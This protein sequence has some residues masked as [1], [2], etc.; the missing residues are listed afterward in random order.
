MKRTLVVALCLMSLARWRRPPPR[1]AKRHQAQRN[2]QRAFHGRSSL[3]TA[4]VLGPGPEITQSVGDNADLRADANFEAHSCFSRTAPVSQSKAGRCR[5]CHID[6]A[7]EIAGSVHYSRYPGG[8]IEL[9]FRMARRNRCFMSLRHFPGDYG[10]PAQ[11]KHHEVRRNNGGAPEEELSERERFWL[12]F[13]EDGLS[14]F[15][16]LAQG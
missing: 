13:R 14:E 12:A 2:H 5:G 3:W 4:S 1:A 7:C 9:G 10:M 8:C 11:Q 15:N 16:P 6:L